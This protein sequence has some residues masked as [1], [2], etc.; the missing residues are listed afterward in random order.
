MTTHVAYL[1][2]VFINITLEGSVSP[3]KNVLPVSSQCH[4][5]LFSI[6]KNKKILQTNKILCVCVCVCVCVRA[7][8]HAY[9][10][11]SARAHLVSVLLHESE[12][13]CAVPIY[14]TVPFVNLDISLFLYFR[15][16][17][18]FLTR[19]ITIIAAKIDTTYTHDL[20]INFQVHF[21]E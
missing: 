19:V 14:L 1:C 21:P 20:A 10:C 4:T 11:V 18:T 15:H 13:E 12:Q 9:V 16:L 8:A 5:H 17:H 7:R 2:V 6:K 3:K